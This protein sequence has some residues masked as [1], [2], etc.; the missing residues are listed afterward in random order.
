MERIKSMDKKIEANLPRTLSH[1]ERY[2]V[3]HAVRTALD[4]CEGGIVSIPDGSWIDKE[5]IEGIIS[6]LEAAFAAQKVGGHIA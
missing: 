4:H 3:I 2:F 6:G 5:D 1:A